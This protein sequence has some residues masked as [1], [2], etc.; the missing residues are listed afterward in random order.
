MDGKTTALLILCWGLLSSAALLAQSR[1]ELIEQ[2]A[3]HHALGTHYY[4]VDWDS[5][6][7]YTQLAAR[8]RENLFADSL[9]I[10][11]GK[12]NFNAGSALR[13]RSSYAKARPYLERALAVYGALDLTPDHA[14]RIPAT[15]LELARVHSGLG[16][17]EK[18]KNQ[19]RLAAAIVSAAT[20][21]SMHMITARYPAILSEWSGI[22][23]EQDSLAAAIEMSSRA[24]ALYDAL[25]EDGK[26]YLGESLISRTNLAGALN[27][28]G[29]YS[30]ARM[31][32]KTLIAGYTVYEDD[33]NLAVNQNNLADMLIKM[34]QL[35]EARQTLKAAKRIISASGDRGLMAQNKDH[36]GALLEAEGKPALAAAAF[37]EAQAFLLP[38]YSPENI[39]DAPPV[40]QLKYASN[41]ADLFLY[42]NDQA[43]ALGAMPVEG[44]KYTDAQLTLYRASDALL[45]ELRSQHGGEATQLFWRQK[46]LPFYEAAIRTCHRAGRGE[47]AFYF[48]EKSKAILLYESLADSDALRELPD[49][50]RAK[51]SAL[52]VVLTAAKAGLAEAQTRALG[53]RIIVDAQAKLDRFRTELRQQYPRYRSL[54]ENISVPDPAAFYN[55]RLGPHEQT[56]VHYF[57]G[58]TITFALTLDAGGVR[59]TDLGPSDSVRKVTAAMLGYFESSADIPNDPAGF[60]TAAFAAYNAL[61]LPLHLRPRQQLLII[62]DGPLTYLPFPALLTRPA[63]GDRLG[64]LP[65]L[66]HEHPLA[67]GH[68]T[69]ILNRE[70]IPPAGEVSITAFA[71]FTDGT[72]QLNYPT[73]PFSQDELSTVSSAFVTK[74]YKDDNATLSAFQSATTDAEILHLSTHAFSS[75]QE[76]SPLIAFH[77]QPLY[78]RDLYHENLKADLVVLSACQTNVG[79][80]AGGEGVLGLG[81][82]FIQ[83]GASSIIASLWNVNARGSSR[84]LGEFYQQLSRGNTKGMALHNA[85]LSYL[86]DA[87]LR[88][89]DKSPYLWAGLT[90][91]GSEEELAPA[92][93]LGIQTW[94]WF[95]LAGL[96]GVGVLFFV[97]KRNA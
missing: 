74:L 12:S 86:E 70:S 57:F 91:Y 40:A 13:Y 39:T 2:A 79:K 47:E 5:A 19:L 64:D 94:H 53:L 66:I 36:F 34:G 88:D 17:Y 71:P 60:A 92:P 90:Y 30:A 24:V 26:D 1:Q 25:I 29:K 11:L 49:S 84:V 61:I 55:E 7:L 96:L 18:A 6:V 76:Q 23:M 89:L 81:R 50:L 27:K 62:P 22:L 59:T 16:D 82:G 69:S 67:Y 41:G 35:R 63:G 83:A 10:D 31:E 8:E 15:Y 68:S 21:E 44:T 97:T 43:R 73:L 77:D 54:T 87:T 95:L 75:T 9:N 14:H 20:E 42:I 48:F 65:Y 3:E 85:Q 4:G 72:A 37:Q 93:A 38:E 52:A 46:A 51:E 45:D 80:L 78:L 32:Y 58:P 28:Q 56:L 33:Y